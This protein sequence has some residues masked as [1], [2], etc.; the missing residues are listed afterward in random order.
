LNAP[1]PALD[2]EHALGPIPSEPTKPAPTKG[3]LSGLAKVR[4]AIQSKIPFWGS[5]GKQKTD[6]VNGTAGQQPEDP[7][8]N[9]TSDMVDV[10]DTLGT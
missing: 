4:S 9:Y 5:K 7:S 10:L 3:E 8:M 6:N 2:E 1:M